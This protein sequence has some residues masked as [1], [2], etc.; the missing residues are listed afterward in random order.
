MGTRFV[1]AAEFQANLPAYL[2]ALEKEGASITI[3]RK[4]NPLGILSPAPKP[5]KPSKRAWGLT[6]RNWQGKG[7]I[8]D[9][10]VEFDMTGFYDCLK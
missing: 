3:T 2:D 4:G 10:I 8:A 1:T 5:Q 9:D 7:R 6:R